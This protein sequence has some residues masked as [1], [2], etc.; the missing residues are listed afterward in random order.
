LRVEG[1]LERVEY[2]M[3]KMKRYDKFEQSQFT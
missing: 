2:E 1:T 3:P